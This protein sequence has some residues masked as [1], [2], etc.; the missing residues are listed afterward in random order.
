MRPE[1]RETGASPATPARRS[2]LSN[3]VMSPPVAARNSVR[4]SAARGRG[5]RSA[6]RRSPRSRRRQPSLPTVLPISQG[7]FSHASP[8][9]AVGAGLRDCKQP[10]ACG[11][12]HLLMDHDDPDK[13]IADLEGQLAEQRWTAQPEHRQAEAVQRPG[14]TAEDVRNVAFSESAFGE[15]GYNPGEVD[16]FLGRVEAALQEQTGHALTLEQVR[17]TVFG[18][19]PIGRRGY[20][21]ADVDA[22]LDR[23]EIELT[24]RAG[25]QPVAYP[26][27]GGSQHHGATAAV[28]QPA[29]SGEPGFEIRTESRRR[30]LGISALGGPRLSLL[31]VVP[32]RRRR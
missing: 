31:G 29:V 5:G 21:V 17:N 2:A 15:R 27:A 11:W 13:R 25:H 9:P 23:V 26:G 3:A 18:K 6:H 12:D 14:L 32:T 8:R 4:S 22:F 7:H 20:A 24:R 1:S 28:P 16:A 10:A 19:P 30:G